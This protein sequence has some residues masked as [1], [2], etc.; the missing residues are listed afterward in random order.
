MRALLSLVLYLGGNLVPL[1]DA[2]VFHSTPQRVAANHIES[3]DTTCHVE[4]CELGAPVAATPPATLLLQLGRFSRPILST[5]A[6]P[7]VDA[8]RDRAPI[9]GL[10][11]RAPPAQG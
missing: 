11:S 2:V 8:P 4:R 9:S 7:S 1:V 5:P 3:S 6:S 10:G